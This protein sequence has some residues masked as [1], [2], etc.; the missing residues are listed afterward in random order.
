MH[1]KQWMEPSDTAYEVTVGK[2]SHVLQDKWIAV[3]PCRPR[4][5]ASLMRKEMGEWQAGWDE[6]KKTFG[7]M[8]TSMLRPRDMT[9]AWEMKRQ[10][11]EGRNWAEDVSR[12]QRI[13]NMFRQGILQLA[14]FS[15]MYYYWK[16]LFLSFIHWS[17]R[18]WPRPADMCLTLWNKI[19]F[20]LHSTL[21][22]LEIRGRAQTCVWFLWIFKGC[23]KGQ[24]ALKPS[25]IRIVS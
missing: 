12:N 21:Y 24:E 19:S 15:N 10:K 14:W 20:A 6:A 17:L 7:C 2:T 11:Q 23:Q 9:C 16:S 1:D 13:A 18:G 22:K 25:H 4:G 3:S 5:L 8:R